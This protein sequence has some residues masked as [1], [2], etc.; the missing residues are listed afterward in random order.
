M[1]RKITAR[2]KPR[3]FSALRAKPPRPFRIPATRLRREAGITAREVSPFPPLEIPL[4]PDQDEELQARYL[5][6]RE[7]TNGSLPEFIVWEWLVYKRKL[8]PG[9]DFLFQAPFM[10]GRTQFGGFILDFY[11]PLRHEGWM[12][13]GERYHLFNPADRAKNALVKVMLAGQGIKVLEMW[14]DDLLRRPDFVLEAAW[15]RSSEVA[16]K[17][18]V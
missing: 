6:W 15:F 14:E 8:L 16:K 17:A 2:K 4:P 18:V 10:G 11:F 7:A 13:Q 9:V 5:P 12:V 1:V 3:R